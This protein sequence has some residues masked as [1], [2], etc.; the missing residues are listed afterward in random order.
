MQPGDRDP[1][2]EAQGEG[3]GRAQAE[4]ASELVR[5]SVVEAV[6][7][8]LARLPDELAE[9]GLAASALT[10]AAAMDDPSNSATSKSMC[11]ARLHDALEQLRALAPEQEEAD[12]VERARKRRADRLAG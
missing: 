10:L 11:A 1:P 9:S 3:A 7:R 2:A 12:E 5:V 4:A 8:D 6:Q